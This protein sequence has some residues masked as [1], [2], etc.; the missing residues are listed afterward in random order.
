L[1]PFAIYRLLFVY[2]GMKNKRKKPTNKDITEAIVHISQKLDSLFSMNARIFRDYVDFQK[3]EEKFQKFL[4]K[5]YEAEIKK[6]QDSKKS[7]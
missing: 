4:N 5:K 7:K 6:E 3:N 1:K 2:L